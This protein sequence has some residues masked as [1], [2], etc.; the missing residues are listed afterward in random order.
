MRK[1]L[2]TVCF[3][4]V[5]LVL[6]VFFG[7]LLRSKRFTEIAVENYHDEHS[8]LY[9]LEDNTVDVLYIG[10]SHVFSSL[11]PEDIFEK[12]GITG[13]VQASSCQKVWQSYYYLQETYYTQ[14]PKVVVLDTFMA[15]SGDAQ[16]EAFNREAIDKMKLSPAK[17]DAIRTAVEYNP[18]EEKA[19][20]YLFPLLRFHDRWEELKE[21]DFV[22]F[23]SKQDAP[24]KGFL[25]RTGVVPAT[26]NAEAYGDTGVEP[27][28][29]PENCREYLDKIKKLCDEN[30]SELLLIKFPTCLWN[31]AS[32][33]AIRQWSEENGVAFLDYNDD[34]ALRNEVAID[35]ATESLDGGNHLNYAGAMKM[36]EVF[37]DYLA[38][39]YEF[40]DKRDDAKYQLWHDDYAYYKRCVANYELANTADLTDYLKQLKN[41]GYTA[42]VSYNNIDLSTNKE[43]LK[44]L[45]EFGIPKKFSKQ[46]AGV[47]NL[48][49]LE[50]GNS[51]YKNSSEED[52]LFA[53]TVSGADWTVS[54]KTQDGKRTFS[55]VTDRK[56]YA[57]TVDGIQFVIWD[58]LTQK[59]VDSSYAV[60]DENGMLVLKR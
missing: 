33:A 7:D 27:A 56:E 35:W 19:A 30:G 28:A 25:A 46:A 39:N 10:S 49:V 15:L 17:V 8:G 3:L 42:F 9:E 57:E 43:A 5:F 48:I 36:T 23:V 51:L 53:D 18:N 24:A 21:E 38:E 58:A 2:K 50:N 55:C 34:E 41:E 47:N 20:S 31:G 32:S 44:Q 59:V 60:L 22:W 16:T 4:L 1:F 6:L 26:F 14:K 13:Y 54:V 40:E 12:H 45:K 37:G 11:S 52:I 29:M